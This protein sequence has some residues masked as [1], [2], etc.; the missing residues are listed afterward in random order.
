MEE[1]VEEG[2]EEEGRGGGVEE[3]GWRS[4]CST[5]STQVYWSLVVRTG[6]LKY[7]IQTEFSPSVCWRQP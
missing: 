1:G 6:Q 7:V 3:E 5:C 2:V 4:V